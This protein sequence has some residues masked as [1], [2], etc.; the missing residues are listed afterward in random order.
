MSDV[1]ADHALSRG[2]V[3]RDLCLYELVEKLRAEEKAKKVKAIILMQRQPPKSKELVSAQLR[4]D[5]IV[6][7]PRGAV[8][9]SF[10]IC[11]LSLS[12]KNQCPRCKDYKFGAM[13]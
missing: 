12:L 5:R 11:D 3:D 4:I 6:V 1:T 10:V 13:L 2:A 7:N 8:Q 9:Q